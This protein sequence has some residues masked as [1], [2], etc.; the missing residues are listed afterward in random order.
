MHSAPVVR[1]IDQAINEKIF[2]AAALI[3]VKKGETIFEEYFGR[4]GLSNERRVTCDT[5]FDLASLT[6][7]LATT[8]CWMKMLENHPQAMDSALFTW[9]PQIPQ[10]K[11]EVTPRLLL[12]HSS[13]LP[14]WRPYYLFNKGSGQ[15]R[16]VLDC[17]INEKLDY[18]LGAGSIYSD[19]GFI[20]LAHILERQTGKR[21]D[22]VCKELIYGPL[23]VSQK[24]L[25]NPSER[26]VEVA[27]TRLGDIP[28]TVNDL[29]ARALGGISGHAGLFGTARGVAR[30]TLEMLTSLKKPNGFFDQEIMK[31]F[32]TP[33][34]YVHESS[35]ALGFDT[36]SEEGSSCGYLF[37]KSSFGH[38]GFTG[39]SLWVDPDRELVTVFLTN[40]VIMGESDMRI[41]ILRPKL[42]DE[43]ISSI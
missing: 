8:P 6:K 41:K 10:D 25:F 9:I 17:I 33:C 21:L 22:E 1:T 12:A 30:L 2:T 18:P 34:L 42:H 24:L 11:R 32:V 35:R 13:G 16:F 28:K 43:I 27:E 4:I 26:C 37:S 5:L 15:Y 39:T 14:A 38:T 20:I 7:V 40:R 23:D 31:L 29:N 36:K 19:L 3:V